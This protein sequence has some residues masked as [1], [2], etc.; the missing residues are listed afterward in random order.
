MQWAG[1]TREQGK[2]QL[3]WGWWR[4]DTEGSSRGVKQEQ[5]LGEKIEPAL[6]R[7]GGSQA[8]LRAQAEA[9][10]QSRPAPFGW[11]GQQ[12]RGPLPR[13]CRNTFLPPGLPSCA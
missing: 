11:G 12:G 7:G 10:G 4:G 2:G 13:I 8:G 5:I 1:G 9:L 3:S 6:K